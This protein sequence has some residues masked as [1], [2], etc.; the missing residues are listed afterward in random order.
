M[1][2]PSPEP[3]DLLIESIFDILCQFYLLFDAPMVML[4]KEDPTRLY[5]AD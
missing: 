1:L 5:D 4:N 3:Q 2:D